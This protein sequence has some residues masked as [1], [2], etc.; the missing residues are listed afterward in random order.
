MPK[1]IPV[2][3][4]E[5]IDNKVTSLNEDVNHEQYPTAQAVKDY[6]ENNGGSG[7]RVEIC[8]VLPNVSEGEVGVLY[9]VPKIFPIKHD[10]N[11]DGVVNINDATYFLDYNVLDADEY[12]IDNVNEYDFNADGRIDSRDSTYMKYMIEQYDKY[13]FLP[14]ENR[15]ERIN[16]YDDLTNYVTKASAIGRKTENN[17]EI[18]TTYKDKEF[19]K[20]ITPYNS[21]ILNSS[22][23]FT[24]GI[25]YKN[26]SISEGSV[27]F[28]GSNISGCKAFRILEHSGTKGGNGTYKLSPDAFILDFAYNL[29]NNHY[30]TWL[31]TDTG[32]NNRAEMISS[33]ITFP[34]VNDS[35]S[36]YYF[37][38]N[39]SQ[40]GFDGIF[41][42][43]ALAWGD[44]TP[45]YYMIEYMEN[46]KDKTLDI[47][48]EENTPS[49]AVITIHKDTIL[50]KTFI[51]VFEYGA[52]EPVIVKEVLNG[53]QIK[54]IQRKNHVDKET[55]EFYIFSGTFDVSVTNYTGLESNDPNVDFANNISYIRFYED[56]TT[57]NGIVIPTPLE[58]GD[59]TIEGWSTATGLNN[60]AVGLGSF[61]TG[62][63][64]I[65]DGAYSFVAG[66]QNIGGFTSFVA[67]RWNKVG[68]YGAAFG[69][70]NEVSG[71]NSLSAGTKNKINGENSSTFGESNT[72][73]GKNS[74]SIGYGNNIKGNNS[75]AFGK[76]NIV[77]SDDTIS[78]GRYNNSYKTDA[79]IEDFN[80]N[81]Y[82]IQ[83]SYISVDN[84]ALKYDM[85]T[86]TTVQN[87]Y[88]V[89]LNT[90]D[91]TNI[92]SP[93]HLKPNTTYIMTLTLKANKN[94]AINITL[95]YG[96]KLAYDAA[97]PKTELTVS[98]GYHNIKTDETIVAFKFTT[99]VSFGL[100]KDG[101]VRDR[102]FFRIN[103]SPQG[104][105]ET[106]VYLT[107]LLLDI[108]YLTTIGNGTSDTNRS[109]AFGVLPDGSAEIQSVG[110]SDNSIV[111]K[112]YVGD[113]YATK[114]HGHSGT[115]SKVSVMTGS[116]Y[117]NEANN[118]GINIYI[119]TNTPTSNSSVPIGS[120]WIQPVE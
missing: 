75:V 48:W 81:I 111:T 73:N 94:T 5:S 86:S 43:C 36:S 29:S 82:N 60:K 115:Y 7:F 55:S 72:I 99:P 95:R 44:I 119:G 93:Y 117:N 41:E 105:S 79:L 11:K 106:Y 24:N 63:Q 50:N 52:F 102:L 118:T 49:A 39:Q 32:G 80:K 37:V 15:Y 68:Q 31:F 38:N 96:S 100:D 70:L 35:H 30:S 46:G 66:R 2:Q 98:N 17:G 53:S 77:N 103:S 84:K 62:N 67:G 85:T 108:P 65:A 14:T 28:G 26:K 18:F 83:K 78:S 116:G 9:L 88:S 97:Y 25:T 10:I 69:Q 87:N 71:N 114:S 34:N 107:K 112:K 27:S 12:P 109:N 45:D 33:T 76:G 56:V 20:D 89:Q 113:N 120:L 19:D 61:V 21:K 54:G 40:I 92:A 90:N 23:E 42:Q 91:S 74:F 57:S 47:D 51:K 110:S 64:N 3:K 16:N 59:T 58:L 6:V 1:I 4:L 104:L 8:E 13:I 22:S 101:N